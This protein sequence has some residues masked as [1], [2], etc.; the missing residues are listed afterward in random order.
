MM[1]PALRKEHH[2]AHGGAALTK[3]KNNLCLFFYP[4]HIFAGTGV[5]LQ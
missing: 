1:P 2:S 4:F 5:D 3:S